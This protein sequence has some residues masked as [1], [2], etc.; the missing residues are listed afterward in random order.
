MSGQACTAVTEGGQV[1]P[2]LIA[3]QHCPPSREKKPSPSEQA[4]TK[5][6][7]TLIELAAIVANYQRHRRDPRGRPVDH[8]E[9]GTFIFR[10]ITFSLLP[11]QQ[12]V[13]E[14]GVITNC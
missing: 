8:H 13:T 11:R 4:G 7:Q 2:K 3:I 1:R 14:L 10:G 9:L 5:K 6:T 12:G